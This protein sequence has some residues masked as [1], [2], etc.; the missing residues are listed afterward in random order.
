MPVRRGRLLVTVRM[1]G[2]RLVVLPLTALGLVAACGEV[3]RKLVEI[4]HEWPPRVQRCP[5]KPTPPRPCRSGHRR[6]YRHLEPFP[7][8]GEV[9][10][11][12]ERR[13]PVNGPQR[14]RELVARDAVLMRGNASRFL[15]RESASTA[16]SVDAEPR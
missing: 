3:G 16:E 8:E 12:W 14:I 10:R 6:P 11:R 13:R 9:R 2:A 5:H 7:R 4:V 15:V 1:G